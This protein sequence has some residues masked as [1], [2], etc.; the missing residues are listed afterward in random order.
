MAFTASKNIVFYFALFIIFFSISCD[1]S[2]DEEN[3][4]IDFDKNSSQQAIEGLPPGIPS[5]PYIFEGEFYINGDFG[6]KD[7]KIISK[8]GEL[9]SPIV[10]TSYGE[11]KNLIIGPRNND[12][13]K[14]NIEFYLI[15]QNGE[16]IKAKEEIPF[17]I[18]NKITNKKIELNFE[19]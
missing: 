19:K 6:E 3:I 9:E 2:K 11:F 5:Y 16:N 10:T 8:L 13:I 12:D 7:S 17:E 1:S 18:L 4:T 15:L 14:N